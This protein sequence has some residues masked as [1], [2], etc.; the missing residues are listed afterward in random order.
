MAI[1]KIGNAIEAAKRLFHSFTKR[2]TVE[3]SRGR[4]TFKPGMFIR[5]LDRAHDQLPSNL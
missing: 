4:V 1:D 3:T 5:C 2:E